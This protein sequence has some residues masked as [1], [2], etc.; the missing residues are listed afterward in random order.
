M[1]QV[2]SICT[3]LLAALAGPQASADA[4]CPA[5]HFT[6]LQAVSIH[7]KE[8]EVV[9]YCMMSIAALN[10]HQVS[11][12]TAYLAVQFTFLQDDIDTTLIAF[13]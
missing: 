9:I 12:D 1:N 5:L 6:F 8:H 4:A 11:P 13:P 2:V 3:L 7:V 10:R